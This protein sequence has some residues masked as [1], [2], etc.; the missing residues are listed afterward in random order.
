MA[1]TRA[2]SEP[3]AARP[4]RQSG[5]QVALLDQPAVGQIEHA[6]GARG[7]EGGA[8]LAVFVDHQAEGRAG[9]CEGAVDGDARR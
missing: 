5:Q 2:P 9:H 8:Q 7:A 3:S 4:R 6:Q 1:P